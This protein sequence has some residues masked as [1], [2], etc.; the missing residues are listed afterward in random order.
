[1]AHDVSHELRGEHGKWASGGATIHRLASE[2]G[3]AAEGKHQ[4]GDRVKYKTGAMG[5]V[6]HIDEKG[7]PHIVWD[8]GRGKPVRTPAHHLTKV[9]DE[10]QK[11][12][13]TEK[14]A[15]EV[16]AK[17]WR[18]E[19]LAEI[20]HVP[21]RPVPAGRLPNAERTPTGAPYKSPRQAGSRGGV[22]APT[23]GP[24]LAHER[25]IMD[26]L[27]DGQWHDP[28]TESKDRPRANATLGR[29][30]SSGKVESRISPTSQ[31]KQWRLKQSGGITP[32]LQAQVKRIQAE[33]KAKM[34]AENKGRG[35]VT[36]YRDV[37][38][39]PESVSYLAKLPGGGMPS[40]T[41]EQAHREYQ[42]AQAKLQNPRITGPAAIAANRRDLSR[43]ETE[44][45][46][47]GA[48]RTGGNT[49]EMP[50]KPGTPEHAAEKLK[51]DLSSINEQLHDQHREAGAPLYSAQ[52][53]ID[54]RRN[55][56]A[57]QVRSGQKTIVVKVPS[58]S[59]IQMSP[60]TAKY[61]LYGE[62]P[63]AGFERGTA[64]QALA[65]S[66]AKR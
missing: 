61:L 35:G 48:R 63:G 34:E 1:M 29:L 44:L 56:V 8:R 58:G 24:D 17:N 27:A 41:F 37:L 36:E 59:E 11:A 32:E 16:T 42:Q 54:A 14:A 45:R 6:H 60:E 25:F 28:V 38:T 49:W 18:Q 62:Q 33:Q 40:R 2:A 31:T 7:T 5:T 52:E 39:R 10:K 65:R 53:L 20:G 50:P 26:K 64:A 46:G 3:K 55:D 22:P 57:A 4:K 13:A 23:T 15:R 30:E 66:R 19:K 12:A 47:M 21:R 9:G 43:L 51:Q